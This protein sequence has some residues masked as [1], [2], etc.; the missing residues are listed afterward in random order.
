MKTIADHILDICQNSI[1]AKAKLI[2][3]SISEDNIADL[4]GVVI[5]DNGDGMD[6]ETAR[7][8]TDA[9]FTSRK[10]RRFGLGLALLRQNAE[11]AEG[12]LSL[13]SEPGNGTEVTAV[14]RRNH[15]D[16]IPVGNL[17]ETIVLLMISNEKLTFRYS[18]STPFGEFSIN[19]SE[20]TQI[21]G[22]IPL[23]R[24]EVRSAVEDYIKNNLDDIQTTK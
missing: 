12:N 21:F 24:K 16:R 4:Y 17:P 8:A 14:F 23:K 11:Q 3:I 2:E 13:K 10:T 22:N 15:I 1:R 20:I 9:F 18:H 6:E 5:R 19:S 7:N